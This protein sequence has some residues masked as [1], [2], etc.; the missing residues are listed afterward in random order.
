M[1]KEVQRVTVVFFIESPRRN[2]DLPSRES[3]LEYGVYKDVVSGLGRWWDHEPDSIITRLI[4]F[5]IEN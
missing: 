1:E 5:Y 2:R 3:R 4:L